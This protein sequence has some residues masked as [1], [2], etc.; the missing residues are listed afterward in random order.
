MGECSPKTTIWS[1]LVA[2]NKGESLKAVE[3]G[4][5]DFSHRLLAFLQRNL[6]AVCRPIQ[7]GVAAIEYWLLDAWWLLR[8]FQKPSAEEVA[9]V[10]DNVTIMFK[11]FERQKQA[12]ALVKSILKYYPGVR[13]VIADDSAKPLT[14]P[15]CSDVNKLKIIKMPFNSG[16]CKGLNL[17][18]AE[19]ETPFMVRLDDDVLFT[20]RTDLARELRF[21]L[22]HSEVDLVGMPWIDA[23]KAISTNR[24]IKIYMRIDMREAPLPLKMPHATKI[25]NEHI[26][27][28]KVSNAYLAR[29]ESIRKVGWDD[30]IRMIDHHDFF[31]RAAGIL[32]SVLSLDSVLFHNHNF[33]SPHYNRYRSDWKGDAAYLRRV[34]YNRR[35]T[36][37]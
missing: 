24:D 18:L 19:I 3:R 13:I 23:C 25:D 12:K 5:M 4:T 14:V 28:G 16:L 17:A 1:K 11:S 22:A 30:N 20:R 37:V 31:Y 21:L 34:R 32:V 6:S 27:L 35:S 15:N 36:R 10:A 7:F 2:I 9:N 8:G 26:V 29:T 33:F